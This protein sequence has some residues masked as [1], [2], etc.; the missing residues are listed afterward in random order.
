MCTQR[1]SGFN[2]FPLPRI[3][4]LAWGT[5]CYA[6]V[7]VGRDNGADSGGGTGHVV[8]V[9]SQCNRRRTRRPSMPIL[10]SLPRGAGDSAWQR[11]RHTII[12][13]IRGAD[14]EGEREPLEHCALI[15]NALPT[16]PKVDA[17]PR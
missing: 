6:T 16:R 3:K 1:K 12:R 17:I 2:G 7:G 15:A 5:H 14:A 4:R 13:S 11:S 9:E 10:A 8:V